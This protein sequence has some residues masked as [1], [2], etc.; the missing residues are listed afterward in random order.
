MSLSKYGFGA[1]FFTI[2][3][4][5]RYFFQTTNKVN[6]FYIIITKR[7]KYL[8]LKH[9]LIFVANF[10]SMMRNNINDTICAPATVPGTGAISVVRLSGKDAVSIADKVLGGVLKDTPGYRV[11]FAHVSD[12]NGAVLDDVLATVFRAP[13]S[14]TG[15][16]SVEISCHASSYIVEQLLMLLTSAGARLADPGEFTR[17]AFVNGKMDLAEAESVADLIASRTEASHKVAMN[18]MKGGFS[19]ELKKMRDE[20][21]NLVTLMELELDFSEEDVQFADRDALT[22][23]AGRIRDHAMGLAESF[24]AGNAVKNGLPVVIVGATNAGK[25]TLLNTLLGEERAI[26]S[27]QHG[28]T[29]DTVEECL[30][31]DGMLFRFIDTAGIRENAGNIERKGIERTFAKIDAASVVLAVMD[32]SSPVRR[33]VESLRA[34]LGHV[35][36][37]QQKL[38]LLMNKADL[39]ASGDEGGF[40]EELTERLTT[41][42]D[43]LQAVLPEGYGIIRDIPVIP[44]S[45]KMSYGIDELRGALAGYMRSVIGEPGAVLVT[46][47]RHA[48][49]LRATSAAL[50][51]VIQGLFDGIPTDLVAQ[52]VREAIYHLG[53]ITGEISTEEVL[54][55]VF[56]KFCV[57]K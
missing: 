40:S 56:G 31:I 41:V 5:I 24:K 17:R 27:E 12:G 1:F 35:D 38:M 11:R 50:D 34:V 23:L 36:L 54:G 16:D 52:D 10:Q 2:V 3:R 47:L 30:N 45:A 15:E 29:R 55:N 9:F 32:I 51:R 14:Y 18:Q 26:V 44:V 8:K 22:V 33:L 25:S 37:G 39:Y 7:K 43:R 21:L 53:E 46:N 57:G 19:S 42:Y 4:F 48:E 49:A 13:H 6:F 20:L 28:T